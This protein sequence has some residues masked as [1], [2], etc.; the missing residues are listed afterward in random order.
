MPRVPAAAPI[1]HWRMVVAL[2]AVWQ[3]CAR[4]SGGAPQWLSL[5]R[6]RACSKT[7]PPLATSVPGSDLGSD[8]YGLCRASGVP[9]SITQAYAHR[10]S[11]VLK[12]P[13]R[14]AKPR[15]RKY[16]LWYVGVLIFWY[17]NGRGVK[18]KSEFSGFF[19]AVR[20]AL[21]RA[22]ERCISRPHPIR[23]RT[24]LAHGH[25]PPLSVGADTLCYPNPR[26]HNVS[27]TC[28]SSSHRVR[29]HCEPHCQRS[30][31][32]WYIFLSQ[33]GN[34]KFVTIMIRCHDTVSYRDAIV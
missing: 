33:Q 29:T 9:A 6:P 32:A 23:S 4:A 12:L 2:V 26:P 31:F 25:F 18:L 34:E 10:R 1:R 3:L 17:F 8:G 22:F 19:Y 21:T 20:C 14:A 16:V 13:R 5:S 24:L 15:I 28:T 7:A 27:P 11:H 30:Q